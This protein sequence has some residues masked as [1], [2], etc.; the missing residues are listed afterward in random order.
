MRAKR[1]VNVIGKFSYALTIPKEIVQQL[2]IKPSDLFTAK[3]HKKKNAVIFYKIK[4]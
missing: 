2:D 3:A 1:K 4:G